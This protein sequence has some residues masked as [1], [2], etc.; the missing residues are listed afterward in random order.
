MSKSAATTKKPA[1]A[2]KPAK[3]AKPIQAMLV[4]QARL[5]DL[6]KQAQAAGTSANHASYQLGVALEAIRSEDVAYKSIGTSA[7]KQLAGKSVADKRSSAFSVHY[8]TVLRL[9]RND[10]KVATGYVARIDK[11]V[12]D[13][14][15]FDNLMTLARR[16]V[17]DMPAKPSKKLAGK[18]GKVFADVAAGKATV[19]TISETKKLHTTPAKKQAQAGTDKQTPADKQ[20]DARVTAVK[21]LVSAIESDKLDKWGI[22]Q[23]EV[24]LADAAKRKQSAKK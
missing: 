10:V 23:L 9:T 11:L 20:A 7:R 22:L 8:R 17:T 3:Q 15:S 1:T 6:T 14:V 5:A 24:A 16:S 2:K 12:A 18:L 13:G 19:P 21:L 4:A